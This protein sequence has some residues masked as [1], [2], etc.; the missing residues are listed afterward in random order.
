MTGGGM[1]GRLEDHPFTRLT[2]HFYGSLFRF[3]VLNEAGV[4]AF[5]RLVWESAGCSSPSD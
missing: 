4:E 1:T 5:E 2:R 3:D